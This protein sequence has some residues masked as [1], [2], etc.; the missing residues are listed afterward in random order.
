MYKAA[1]SVKYPYVAISPS[2]STKMGLGFMFLIDAEKHADSMNVLLDSYEN[3]PIWNKEFWKT[4]P[5]PWVVIYDPLSLVEGF[6][7]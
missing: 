3:D 5:E 7:C 6:S 4:K 1:G 2:D